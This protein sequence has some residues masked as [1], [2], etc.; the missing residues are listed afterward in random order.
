LLFG[1]QF[2]VVVLRLNTVGCVVGFDARE[3]L[4]DLWIFAVL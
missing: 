3:E 4:V 1:K 2:A